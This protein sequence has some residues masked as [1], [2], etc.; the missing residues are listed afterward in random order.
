MIGARIAHLFVA[1]SFFW[2]A[3]GCD[4]YGACDGCR[5]LWVDFR[6]DVELPYDVAMAWEGHTASFR[7]EA[8]PELGSR[9]TEL[10]GLESA[11]C[12]EQGFD[13][14]GA[15]PTFDLVVDS[16]GPTKNLRCWPRYATISDT[17]PACDCKGAA[18]SE[19]AECLHT[20]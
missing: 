10:V 13:V 5:N 20:R 1:A 12:G 17:D 4:G 6:G 15:P 11:R 8:D 16:P 19:G 7:C 3:V 18:V 9:V 2:V 14:A